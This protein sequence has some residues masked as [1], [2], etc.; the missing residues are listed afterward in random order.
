LDDPL[1]A[2]QAIQNKLA[3]LQSREKDNIQ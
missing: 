1:A 3:A 2:F